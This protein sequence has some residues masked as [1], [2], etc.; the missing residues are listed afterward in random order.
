[1]N[2]QELL[3]RLCVLFNRINNTQ[4][5]GELECPCICGENPIAPPQDR[6]HIQLIEFVEKA[7]EKEMR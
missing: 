5:K 4:F 2:R 1:M 7:V 3:E 6:T